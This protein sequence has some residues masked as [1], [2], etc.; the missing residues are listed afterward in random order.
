MKT[1]RTTVMGTIGAVVCAMAGCGGVAVPTHAQT[2]AVAAVQSADALG[3]TETPTASYQLELARGE[4]AQAQTAMND[5]HNAQAQDLLERAKADA[6]LAM[7]LRR[8]A[9][10]RTT[11]TAAHEHV[12]QLRRDD[13]ATSGGMT[14][15]AAPSP[16]TPTTTTIT[17]TTGPVAQ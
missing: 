12:D 8:E 2:D 9:Q 16:T 5:G 4:L 6:E 15:A 1:I 10:A 7:A 11:A 14:T 13:T 3:A 17:T